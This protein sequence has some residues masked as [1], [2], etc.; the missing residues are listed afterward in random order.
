MTT[1]AEL[2]HPS[3]WDPAL[4]TAS[5]FI[6]G[7]EYEI[8]DIKNVEFEDY[9]YQ[10]G[11]GKPYWMGPIGAIEDGSLRNN[12]VEFVTVPSTYKE[13]LVLFDMLHEALTLG[14]NP[15]THRTSIHV[16]VNVASL[17]PGQLKHLVLLYALAEPLFFDFVGEKRKNNIHCVPLN[18]TILPG[19]YNNSVDYLI[20]KWSKYT[21][22]NLNPVVSQ[23]TVEF[24]HMFGTG[25]KVLYTHWLTMLKN[26]WDFVYK[27]DPPW[28]G[29]VLTQ[30]FPAQAIIANVFPLKGN[31]LPEEA[32][33]SSMI[34]VKMAFV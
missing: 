13:A 18:Y 24:R 32:Y 11:G 26:L 31:T 2:Y 12:G 6:C 3:L 28:L 4:A 8:E 14:P 5:E 19:Y 33:A 22:F 1:I 21:A 30:G 17:S 27:T 23:G 25:D 29:Q 16:H 34:D 10:I 15:Y 7:T 9:D 20:S